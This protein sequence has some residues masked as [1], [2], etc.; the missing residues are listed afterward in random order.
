MPLWYGRAYPL[1]G[2]NRQVSKKRDQAAF[3]TSVFYFT[4][5]SS[6]CRTCAAHPV[7]KPMLD[8]FGLL[9]KKGGG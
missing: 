9:I 6:F 3:N 4:T 1:I 5:A 2:L 7:S 8:F